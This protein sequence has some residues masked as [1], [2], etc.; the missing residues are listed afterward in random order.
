MKISQWSS[1]LKT[2]SLWCAIKNFLM[3]FMAAGKDFIRRALSKDIRN[4]LLNIWKVIQ[5]RHDVSLGYYY[6]AESRAP[7]G[8]RGIYTTLGDWIFQ[9]AWRVHCVHCVRLCNSTRTRN[10]GRACR[11][12]YRFTRWKKNEL[13]IAAL[14]L[15][16]SG[17]GR[18]SH[19]IMRHLHKHILSLRLLVCQTVQ[20]KSTLNFQQS[21]KPLRDFIF[22][23]S[24]RN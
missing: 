1:F 4:R 8:W 12:S 20:E 15:H 17:K 14:N 11:F 16:V 10:T 21:Q 23:T 24:E 5:R 6:V 19:S 13:R 7:G 2:C 18:T 3:T 22:S 9:F